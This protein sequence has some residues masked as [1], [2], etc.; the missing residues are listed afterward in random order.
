MKFLSGALALVLAGVFCWGCASHRSRPAYHAGDEVPP[1]FLTG[2]IAVVLTNLNGFS[3]RVTATTTSP[4]GFARVRTGDL[5]ARDGFLLF[6]PMLGIKGKRART[7]GGLFFIWDENQ[8]SGYVMSEALQGFAPINGNGTLPDGLSIVNEGIKEDVNGHPCHR[9]QAL[10][11]M[12]NGDKARLTLWQADDARHFPVRIQTLDGVDRL[13]LDFADIRLE[14]PSRVLFLPPDGFTAY[15]TAVALMNELIVRDASLAKKY[16]QGTPD[17]P[18]DVRPNGF[19][20]GLGG[21]H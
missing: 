15:P 11:T 4:E 1:E 21:I 18:Q 10:V 9:C 20:P 5:L 6:Q 8:H 2:P 17:E 12:A 7:E 13:T 19:Q 14:S 16:E 3:A